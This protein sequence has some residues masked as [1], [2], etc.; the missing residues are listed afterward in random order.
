[1]VPEGW[2][3]LDTPQ[4]LDQFRRDHYL[5]VYT[6]ALE[7]TGTPAEAHRLAA[8]V[9]LNVARRYANQAI[10][11]NCDMYLAAQANL[12]YAQGIGQAASAD[13]VSATPQGSASKS[14]EPLEPPASDTVKATGFD[15]TVSKASM[16]ATIKNEPPNG[17]ATSSAFVPTEASH[18]ENINP[19]IPYPSAAAS[20]DSIAAD[21]FPTAPN[22]TPSTQAASS[23][24]VT[25]SAVSVPAYRTATATDIP[26]SQ[27]Y[28]S[29][30]PPATQA[31]TNA[32]IPLAATVPAFTSTTVPAQAMVTILVSSTPANVPLP[33][34]SVPSIYTASPMSYPL[35]TQPTN[36]ATEV[37]PTA[38]VEGMAAPAPQT[39]ATPMVDV[40]PHPTDASEV[41][42]NPADTEYW[43]P[44]R[45]GKPATSNANP[46]SVID[47]DSHSLWEEEEPLD[48][49]SMF[50]SLVN[51][52][53]TLA[54]IASF[55][56]LLYRIN[57][58]L[59]LI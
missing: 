34:G 27:A 12:Q 44:D 43:S 11:Q 25:P 49:P 50:L 13:T 23:S 36:V 39:N 15:P 16:Q 24:I 7:L 10:S 20:A 6:T 40:D 38:T 5:H 53:L 57:L 29:T 4:A 47:P 22:T 3:L 37:H 18:F 59:K 46:A 52:L 30:I 54:G 48:K 55:V 58:I 31:Y 51:G 21:G 19:S 14:T 28:T 41:N 17:L 33:A 32:E 56:Y 35:T 9:F 1:M 8:K 45:D 2:V 26:P 42:Y